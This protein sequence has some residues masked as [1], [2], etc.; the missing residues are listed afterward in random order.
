MGVSVREKVKG[1]GEFWVFVR[2][3]GEALVGELRS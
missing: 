2:L 3:P 1:T